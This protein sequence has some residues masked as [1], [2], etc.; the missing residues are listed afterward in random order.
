MSRYTQTGC[1][2]CGSSD[3]LTIYEDTGW[4]HCFANG[5]KIPPEKVNEMNDDIQTERHIP[6][7]TSTTD[8]DTV[9]AV[10]GYRAYPI[11]SRN[12]S[13]EVV[14]HF[15]VRMST[16]PTGEP[17]AHYYPYTK[18]GQTSAYKVRTLPK[19]F[20]V[21]GDAKGIELFGQ[22]VAGGGRTLVITEGELDAMAVAQAYRDKYN[23]HYPVVSLPSAT[24]I[25]V[26]LEQR[27]WVRGFNEVVLM[28]DND[29]AGQK[30][31]VADQAE[32][33]PVG[34]VAGDGVGQMR[35]RETEND[36]RDKHDQ[37]DDV[38]RPANGFR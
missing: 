30:H 36:R 25:K 2:K 5:C 29:E 24:G 10:S 31:R 15:N 33:D 34:G 13:L 37:A 4:G 21:I 11:S 16:K 20:K 6:V 12:I 26:L 28:F 38:T 18:S 7:R 22:S 8:H 17:E 1:P 27:D 19:S 32:N 35:D 14:E 23:R 3:A 9:A